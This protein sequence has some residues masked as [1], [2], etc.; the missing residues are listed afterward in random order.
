MREILRQIASGLLELLQAHSSDL[1]ATSEWS[2][3]FSVMEF[4]GVG[5]VLYERKEEEEEV[6]SSASANSASLANV[7]NLETVSV[8]T[9]YQ[10]GG[11]SGVAMVTDGSSVVPSE[12]GEGECVG[13]G[14]ENGIGI[15]SDWVWVEEAW[16]HQLVLPNSFDLLSKE[17]IP[18]H[19]P[20][21][22]KRLNFVYL[23]HVHVGQ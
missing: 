4:A 19:D 12:A 10:E 23:I 13:V 18:I 22:S 14:G 15:Q 3:V 7:N 16:H 21:V 6:I 20:Q 1:H 8:D 2:V 11:G 5:L 17:S 9:G